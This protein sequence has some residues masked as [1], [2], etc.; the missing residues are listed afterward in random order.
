[1][2]QLSEFTQTQ[3][4]NLKTYFQE[5]LGLELDEAFVLR[6]YEEALI[7][8]GKAVIK[9]RALKINKPQETAL[10]VKELRL[11][12]SAK[13]LGRKIKPDTEKKHGEV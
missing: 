3:L 1:M 7:E 10:V 5:Q 13:N 2:S 8:M 11:H 12:L 6:A 4:A 9:D